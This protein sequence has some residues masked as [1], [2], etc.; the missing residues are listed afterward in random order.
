MDWLIYGICCNI[1]IYNMIKPLSLPPPLLLLLP[2]T[3]EWVNYSFSSLSGWIF[4]YI[5]CDSHT[6]NLVYILWYFI[7]Y[8]LIYVVYMV[9]VVV[10]VVAVVAVVVV[11]I[12]VVML[13]G[14]SDGSTTTTI[15]T[16]T[17]TTTNAST[18]TSDQWINQLLVQLIEWLID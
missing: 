1:Y 16:T 17:T 8:L 14:G 9:V 6:I 5:Y 11:V 4:N 12:V 10:V 15:T 7:L 13:Y 2:V 18:T 3:N